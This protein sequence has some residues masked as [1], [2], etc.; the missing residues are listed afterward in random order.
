MTDLTATLSRP[1]DA[2]L[3]I[4]FGD[5]AVTADVSVPDSAHAAMV[6]SKHLAAQG[7]VV[8]VR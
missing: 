2:T 1:D 5:G 7:V 6:A 4:E 3:R 8:D